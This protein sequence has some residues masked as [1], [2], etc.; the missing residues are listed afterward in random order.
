MALTGQRTRVPHP[1]G[2]QPSDGQGC[3]AILFLGAKCAPDT[4]GQHGVATLH[5]IEDG[6]RAQLRCPQSR[7]LKA[8]PHSSEWA[9]LV[10]GPSG[11]ALLML[12]CVSELIE[13]LRAHAKAAPH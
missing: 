1:S 6:N 12:E 4:G 9:S 7:T 2:P 8:C 10:C 13:F 11:G 5:L 3:P